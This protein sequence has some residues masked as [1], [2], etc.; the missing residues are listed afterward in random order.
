[1]YSSGDFVFGWI[2]RTQMVLS[3]HS[4][5]YPLWK[6]LPMPIKTSMYLVSSKTLSSQSLCDTAFETN[7]KKSFFSQ[8][9]HLC[10]ARIYTLDSSFLFKIC[11]T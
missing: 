11:G 6:D 9:Y 5:N 1:M 3:D 7:V 8:N 4:A 2:L 10:T